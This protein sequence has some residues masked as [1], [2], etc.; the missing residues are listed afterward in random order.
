[1]EK[2]MAENQ[3][4]LMNSKGEKIANLDFLIIKM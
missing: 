3:F 4:I 1:M 2:K